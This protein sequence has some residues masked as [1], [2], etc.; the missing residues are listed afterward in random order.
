MASEGEITRICEEARKEG[1]GRLE[2]ITEFYA[3]C[4]ALIARLEKEKMRAEQLKGRDVAVRGKHA[5]KMAK[6]VKE[7]AKT[8]NI[9]NQSFMRKEIRE[10]EGEIFARA[11]KNA[12]KEG[13]STIARPS[14][15]TC[16]M[17]SLKTF[18]G[19]TS[20]A[21]RKLSELDEL[22]SL[23]ER[24]Q[25]ERSVLDEKVQKTESEIEE[26]DCK[27]KA[28]KDGNKRAKPAVSEDLVE[29]YE[30]IQRLMGD[31]ERLREGRI[32]EFKGAK[33]ASE[34]VEF[35][36]ANS[37]S[38]LKLGFPE[39]QDYDSLKELRSLLEKDFA[40]LTLEE[41]LEYLEYNEKKLSHY[42]P[43]PKKFKELL[44]LNFRWLSKVNSLEKTPFLDLSLEDS[45]ESFKLVISSLGE[46]DG[47]GILEEVL[48][49]KQPLDLEKLG[50][51]VRQKKT[52][53][54]EETVKESA[55]ELRHRQ[56]I[57]QA[58]LAEYLRLGSHFSSAS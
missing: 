22:I 11:L 25:V 46:S 32:N 24:Y 5:K 55:E 12:L 16:H 6:T 27:I 40:D 14:C 31:Y 43:Q 36:L 21:R 52:E 53:Q 44:K 4:L 15:P 56:K 42:T 29:R 57:L 23:Y 28:L 47:A 39:P 9:I 51:A 26:I 37:S 41:L 30:E 2:K 50:S 1:V 13:V 45:D 7:I 34:V 10:E 17:A 8:F 48:K 49:L 19:T 3:R 54:D 38:L 58:T 33:G 18:A 35:F 20:E